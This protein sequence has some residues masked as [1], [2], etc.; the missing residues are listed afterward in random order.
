M[1][2][3]KK[4]VFVFVLLFFISTYNVK[5]LT[6]Y[7][8]DK[9]DIDIKVN[10]DN[11]FDIKETITANFSV[12]KHGI[13]L[14][15]PL[16]NEV[17]REDRTSYKNKAIITKVKVNEKFTTSRENGN[18]K[19]KIGSDNKTLTGLK[20]YIISY[21]YNIGNDKTNK[22]DELYYNLIGIDWD[23]DISNITFKI[24]M[25]KE[26]DESK[27][28]FSA[29]RYG[30]SGTS[31]ITYQVDGN[32]IT[33]TFNRILYQGETITVRLELPDGYFEKQK[34]NIIDYLIYLIP[35]IF[36]VV[37]ILLWYLYGRDDQVIET[38]EFYPPK[39]KNSLEVGFLYKGK[40][41]QEDVTSLLIYLANKG[42]VKIEEE[43]KKGFKIIKIKEYDGKNEEEKEFLEGLFKKSSKTKDGIEFVTD[44]DLYDS[45]YVTM[46]KILKSINSKENKNSIFEKSASNKSFIIIL[47]II[48]TFCIITIPPFIKYEE[49]DIIMFALLFPGIGFTIM[50][51]SFIWDNSLYIN[52]QAIN[53][54][55]A[56]RIFGVIFGLLF[57]GFPF[58]VM[59]LPVLSQELI[60]LIMYIVGIICVFGMLISLKYLPRRTPYGNE[61]LGKLKGFKTF[62]ET[63]E[64]ERL[65]AMVK[66]NP[67]YFYDILPFT[68]VLGVSKTWIKKFEA[69]NIEAPTWYYGSDTFD[70][71]MFNRFMNN[72]MKVA[73]KSMTSSPSSSS[74]GFSGGGFSGGGFSGGGS[75][76]GG[77]GSW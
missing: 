52:G 35:I 51:Q 55:I 66:D 6:G 3:F 67:T 15:I 77:G 21:H 42:Y 28:G 61:V 50:L 23:T 59:V 29:G 30:E 45:F 69:I 39:G 26:F 74:G 5:A 65:E 70:I 19:I 60:Y 64:K 75:G 17:K 7:T 2:L 10:K 20:E 73:S 48:A 47:M 24:S 71:I 13:F 9:F 57:G 43:G 41:I 8:I 37:S 31:D 1:N 46:N 32:V 27:L 36:L 76:G 18:Y 14:T 25:P 56:A 22:F 44:D 53:S 33:G 68:Y 54:K 58:I 34:V 11:T 49:I 72:T 12:P 4:I 62:L 38:V 40:A 63:A 16:R